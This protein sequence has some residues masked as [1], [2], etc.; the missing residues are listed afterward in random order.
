MPKDIDPDGFIRRNGI[1]AWYIS[2]RN[3]V[4]LSELLMQYITSNYQLETVED[5]QRA[6]IRATEVCKSIKKHLI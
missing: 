6:A 4:P 2:C 5:K 3:G 1:D